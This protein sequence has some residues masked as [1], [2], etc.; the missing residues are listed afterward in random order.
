MALE[1]MKKPIHGWSNFETARWKFESVTMRRRDVILVRTNVLI[2]DL[3]DKL[4]GDSL[5]WLAI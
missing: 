5:G 4:L 1:V 2:S 3:P